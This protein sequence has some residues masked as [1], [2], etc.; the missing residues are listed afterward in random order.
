MGKFYGIGVG[1]GDEKLLT[2]KAVEVLKLLD[3]LL[4]P[5]TQKGKEGIA[6]KIAN[7][8]LKED[9]IIEYIDFPMIVDEEIFVKAGE[10]AAQIIEKY[11]SKGKNV[12][13]ITLGDSGVYSTYGYIVK[14]VKGKVEIETIPG[15]PCFCAAAAMSNKPLV[16]KDEVLSIIPMNTDDEQIEQVISSSDAFV[17]MKVYKRE[18]KLAS[19]LEEQ[20]IA[21]ESYFALKCGFEDAEIKLDTINALK[22]NKDYLTIVHSRKN[23]KRR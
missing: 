5:M 19:I 15:I 6:K 18:E 8:Y 21:E 4:I 23:D 9:L 13:F 1:P 22:K 10:K 20:G 17:F 16:E 3:V 14:A 2:I 7:K 11:V 12:G